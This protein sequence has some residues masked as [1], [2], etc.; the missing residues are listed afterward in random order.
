M[1]A[2]RGDEGVE[3]GRL[4]AEYARTVLSHQRGPSR[5]AEA[6][7]HEMLGYFEQLGKL[8][9]LCT[10][11]GD[12]SLVTLSVTDKRF[13]RQTDAVLDLLGWRLKRTRQS[14]SLEAVVS[15]GAGRR[16]DLASALAVDQVAVEKAFQ[17]GEAYTLTI[18][19]EW[20][21]MRI[22][23]A[24]L[25]LN[26]QIG[27]YAGGLPE[28]MVRD[29]ALTKIYVA[30]NGMD[31]DTLA[32]INSVLSLQT[33]AVSY[34]DRL[35]FYASALSVVRG[36]V[37][38][39]GGPEADSVWVAMC[40]AS[41]ATPGLFLHALLA[42]DDGRLLAWFFTLSQLDFDH[43]RFFT[44]NVSRSK[45]FYELFGH[46]PEARTTLTGLQHSD[47]FTEFLR[48]VPLTDGSVDFPGGP[49]V[50]LVAKGQSHSAAATQSLLKKAHK[51]VAPDVEDEI[52]LRLAGAR[53]NDRAEQIS[54]LDN[55]VAAVRIDRAR[56]ESLDD[57]SALMLAQ[58]YG[59]FR[60]FYPYFTSFTSLTAKD[61]R[62]FFDFA[63]KLKSVNP[64][65]ADLILGQFDSLVEL[66]HSG[67]VSGGIGKA[68]AEAFFRQICAGFGS[69]P[70]LAGATRVALDVVREL[71]AAVLAGGANP[72]RAIAPACPRNASVRPI[73]NRREPTVRST[74]KRSA[75]RP[76]RAFSKCSGSRLLSRC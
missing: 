34:A 61:Y 20:A 44:L 4:M 38:T 9:A 52:L 63:D 58:N 17:K 18:P 47:S 2:A 45:K 19:W 39:P 32:A 10:R 30:L 75:G 21:P 56:E 35:S 73:S 7:E 72:D 74:S 60:N 27:K 6:Y 15:T 65:D 12:H 67:V 69:A 8:L 33:M 28:A 40:G 22:D 68:K 1:F 37:V 36:R 11:S 51:A 55:F 70:D 13:Q 16:Q 3:P 62:A 54:E 24:T 66:L 29:A 53:Y 43:Q 71:A 42:K 5:E 64:V 76:M 49:E 41:P 57:E 14:L 31:S 48:E 59:A 23:D 50:W 46:A 26:F 25:K